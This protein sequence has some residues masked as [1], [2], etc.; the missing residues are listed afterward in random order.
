MSGR[1]TAFNADVEC[2]SERHV[3]VKLQPV[4]DMTK[5]G[6]KRRY[7]CQGHAPVEYTSSDQAVVD[8]ANHAIEADEAARSANTNIAFKNGAPVLEGFTALGNAAGTQE[9]LHALLKRQGIK[10]YRRDRVSPPRPP[11]PYAAI[12]GS[13]PASTDHD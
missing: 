8:A 11:K 6:G 9:D 5:P 10:G 4:Y 1:W 13:L 7:R 12:A 2:G 3:I